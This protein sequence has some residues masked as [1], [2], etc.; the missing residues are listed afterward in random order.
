MTDP[1]RPDEVLGSPATLQLR[2]NYWL[3]QGFMILPNLAKLMIRLMLDRRV[4]ASSKAFL[5][6]TI[7]Y[8]ISPIDILPDFIPFLGQLDDLLLISLG[9]HYLIRSAGPDIVVEYWDGDDDI[10]E[11]VAQIVDVAAGLVPVPI[12]SGLERLLA[13]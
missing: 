10:L 6:V 1:L 8:V 2:D 12:R 11:I 3:S 7:G 5:L 13:R 4:P 9:L